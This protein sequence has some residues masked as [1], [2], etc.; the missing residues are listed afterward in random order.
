MVLLDEIE[1]AHPDLFN[2][3]LQVMDH[4]TLTDNTGRKADF[5]QVILIMTS[6]AGS[7]EMSQASDRLRRRPARRTRSRA[8]SRRSRAS[9]RPEFRNRLDAIVNFKALTPEVMETIVEKFVLELEAQLRERKVAIDLT[10]EARA[11]LATK[12]Y[13]PVFGARPLS[14]LMQTEVRNPLT[15]EILFGRLEHGGTVHVGYDG[16]KLT[17]EYDSLPPPEPRRR[18]GTPRARDRTQ[19]ASRRVGGRPGRCGPGAQAGFAGGLLNWPSVS[20]DLG[21]RHAALL[22]ELERRILVI[23]GAMGTLLQA[24]SLGEDDYRG[25]RLRGHPSEV[26]GNHELL[27]LSRPDVVEA[28][29]REYL[30]AG[31]DIVETN[32]FNGNGALAGRLRHRDLVHE[33]NVAAGRAARGRR[34]RRDGRASRAA[35]AGWPARSGP[36]QQDGLAVARRERPRRPGRHLRRPA[37]PPTTSRRGACSTAA[38]TCCSSR[39]SSTR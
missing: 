21:P 6:N 34:R 18:A 38:S 12:G 35:R 29:H 16:A 2:I 33:M 30:D 15:D 24:R 20:H 27:N 5:R 31:A 7:R 11:H 32:T 23:D 28:A 10:P 37:S 13:D 14:R 17:F 19:R 9:S 25:E 1:K 36:T 3:L 26:K 4:A 8:A 22:R 39:R